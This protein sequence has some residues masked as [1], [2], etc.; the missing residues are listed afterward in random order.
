MIGISTFARFSGLAGLPA[1]LPS[2][3]KPAWLSVV[4]EFNP[5]K[6]NSFP[7]HAARQAHLL[8]VALQAQIVRLAREGRLQ[9]LAPVLTFQSSLDFT[10]STRA[11]ITSRYAFLPA[12][13]SE[14]VLFDLNRNTKL[15]VLLRT[16]FARP[17][18]RLVPPP[19][20]KWRLTVVANTPDD[21]QVSA[22]ITEAGALTEQ[23][24]SL[25]IDYPHDV[26]SLSHIALPFSPT[27]GLYGSSPEPKDNYGVNFGALAAR[28][29]RGVL[30]I[31]PDLLARI[32]W[33][34]FFR[35]MLGRIE[36]RIVSPSGQ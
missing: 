15:G 36:K 33:N 20:R 5:F 3:A 23:A 22:H 21:P 11:V 2:F 26:Y 30:I 28:G 12:N 32:S 10:V 31:G 19:P 24:R 14:L 34:P 7:V 17:I 6:Y 16:V 27:D 9:D 13:D 1:L 18:D 4:P 25:G 8:T 29:E 35:H